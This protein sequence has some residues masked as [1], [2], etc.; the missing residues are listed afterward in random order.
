MR[1]AWD[2]RKQLVVLCEK[3]LQVKIG[4]ENCWNPP[5]ASEEVKLSK[6][7]LMAFP[8][9]LTRKTLGV[10]VSRNMSRKDRYMSYRR[11]YP[12]SDFRSFNTLDDPSKMELLYIH[13]HSNQYS[14]VSIVDTSR[15]VYIYMFV[16]YLFFALLSCGMRLRYVLLITFYSLY[17]HPL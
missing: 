15:H 5:T 6:L 4:D 2:L 16:L 9:Q 13:P 17:L 10:H 14:P 1:K 7:L 3:V 11:G 12:F 8:D